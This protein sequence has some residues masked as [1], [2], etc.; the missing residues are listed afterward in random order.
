MT[1]DQRT[2]LVADDPDGPRE[3][4]APRPA[5]KRSRWPDL[6]MC[7]APGCYSATTDPSGMCS[8]CRRNGG[9]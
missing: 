6:R 3:E 7:S 1:D 2:E 9:R 5:P 8:R 4:Q